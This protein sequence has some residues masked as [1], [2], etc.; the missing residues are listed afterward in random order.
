L[1]DIETSPIIAHVWDIWDQNVGL[2]QIQQDW[3]LLSWSAKWLDSPKVIYM[4]QRKAKDI[5]NDKAI[6]QGLW[7][8][9]NEADIVI[10]QNGIKFDAKKVN[11]RFIQHGMQPP[12]Y[13]KH[14]DTLQ[15]AKR[16]FGFTSNKLAYMTDKLCTKYKKLEH[17]KF[18]GHE[19]W[20]E[21]LKGNP[22]AWR[23]ME[24]YNK[25]DVLSLEELYKKLMPW[26]NTVNFNLYH[27]SEVNTCACGSTEFRSNGHFYSAAGKFQRYRCKKCGAEG[28]AGKNLLTKEKK[29]SLLR[30]T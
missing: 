30:K 12:S 3:H 18:P 21:C 1:F 27:N 29:H 17:K 13:Y 10:T 28:R 15:I 22:K 26:D 16:R 23:E 24:V 25:H 2:N 19:M 11:A 9:L 20:V 5:T 4:D 7:K 8:L 14:I 6:L